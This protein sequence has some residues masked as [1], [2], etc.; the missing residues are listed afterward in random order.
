MKSRPPPTRPDPEQA[1]PAIVDAVV[2][3]A[4]HITSLV[5][6]ARLSPESVVKVAS[7]LI[8]MGKEFVEVGCE[9]FREKTTLVPNT[10]AFNRAEFFNVWWFAARMTGAGS[11]ARH[12]PYFLATYALLERLGAGPL[13]PYLSARAQLREIVG[14]V[15]R[16]CDPN[17]KLDQSG[18]QRFYRSIR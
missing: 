14:R 12:E 6:R 18:E 11:L 10:R 4:N 16:A 5:P 7:V 15:R 3:L 17:S 13:A 1:D 2:D 8:C 9:S